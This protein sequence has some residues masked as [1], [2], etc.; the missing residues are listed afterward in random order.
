M[1][2]HEKCA[3]ST[4]VRHWTLLTVFSFCVGS[5]PYFRSSFTISKETCP[6]CTS[7]TSTS[8][9]HRRGRKERSG[10][11]ALLRGRRQPGDACDGDKDSRGGLQPSFV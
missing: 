9:V 10:A 1:P 6:Y 8:Q 2:H 3:T 11:D 7:M 5:A 4:V